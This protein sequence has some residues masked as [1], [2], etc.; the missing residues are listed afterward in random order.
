MHRN[1]KQHARQMMVELPEIHQGLAQFLAVVPLTKGITMLTGE[2]D[3]NWHT[4]LQSPYYEEFCLK[5][6]GQVITHN[7]GFIGCDDHIEDVILILEKVY[8]KDLDPN[9][10]CWRQEYLQGMYE[11]C[12]FVR[13]D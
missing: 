6:F 10:A 9:L 2:V 4:I 12:A 7:P 1:P 13:L 8:G 11:V 3:D 5:N